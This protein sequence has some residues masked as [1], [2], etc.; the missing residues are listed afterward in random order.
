M[1]VVDWVLPIIYAIVGILII[2]C[3]VGVLTNCRFCCRSRALP[4]PFASMHIGPRIIRLNGQT[5]GGHGTGSG[6][7]TD[8]LGVSNNE[9]TPR[10]MGKNEGYCSEAKHVFPL[11]RVDSHSPCDDPLPCGGEASHLQHT[12]ALTSDGE[13][14]RLPTDVAVEFG[15]ELNDD[16]KAVQP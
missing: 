15:E 11:G 9:E 6:E 13:V 2:T 4:N 16:L 1:A 10:G 5:N 14:S 12:T 7:A 8:S 3:I